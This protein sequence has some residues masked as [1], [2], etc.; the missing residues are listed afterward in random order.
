MQENGKV[1]VVIQKDTELTEVSTQDGTAGISGK[2]DY[3]KPNLTKQ[4][5][6]SALIQS[7]QQAIN[8]GINAYAQLTGDYQTTKLI[9]RVTSVASDVLMIL[10]GGPVGVIAV[11]TKHAM[12]GVNKYVSN[13]NANRT[14][15]YNN[16]QLGVV[17]RQG[18]RYY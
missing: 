6:T 18:S 5:I 4:A 15:E 3:E 2:K 7:G 11:A 16:Q 8:Q 13:V 12:E 10:K 17:L 1:R 9:N 14:L